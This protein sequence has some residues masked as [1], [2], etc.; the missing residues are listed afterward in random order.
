LLY[1]IGLFEFVAILDEFFVVVV[2]GGISEF[3]EAD[4]LNSVSSDIKTIGVI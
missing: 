3:D 1:F 4:F 2:D